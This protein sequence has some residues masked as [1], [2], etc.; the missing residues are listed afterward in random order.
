MDQNLHVKPETIK[1]LEENVGEMLQHIG[2]GKIFMNKTFKKQ[3]TK[4]KIN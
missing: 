4:A 2:L 1:L 3:A